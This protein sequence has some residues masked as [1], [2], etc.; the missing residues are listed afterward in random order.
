M[1]PVLMVL[2]GTGAPGGTSKNVPGESSK[3]CQPAVAVYVSFGWNAEVLYVPRKLPPPPGAQ[4]RDW[5]ADGVAPEWLIAGVFDGDPI[6]D[7]LDPD[8]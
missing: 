7:R 2:P 5:A 6:D 4:L 3:F 8:E 1:K